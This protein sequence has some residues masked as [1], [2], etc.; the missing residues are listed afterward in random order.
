MVL[1][2][3]ALKTINKNPI[4]LNCFSRGGS[5]ILWN[6][7]ISHPSVCHPLQ[8]TLE[9]FG[10]NLRS[11]KYEA[12]KICTLE[13]YNVFNQWKLYKR[14]PFSKRTKTYIDEVFFNKKLGCFYDNVMKFKSENVIYTKEE[15][16]KSRLIIKNNNGISFFTENFFELY[17]DATFIG[18]IRNPI[19]LYESH[20]RRKTP[21]SKSVDTFTHFYHKMVKKMLRDQSEIP[22]FHIIKF[23]DLISDPV[24]SIQK[25]YGW[26]GLDFSDIKKV[27]LKAKP[28]TMEN[29]IIGN[30]HTFGNHYWFSFKELKTFLDPNVNENQIDKISLNDK[31][32]I[33]TDLS[34]IIQNLDY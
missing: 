8:E 6:F 33:L 20:K 21:V 13:K 17:P 15:V 5:N 22:N 24:K 23:E 26:A 3:Q 30:S 28:F 14:K 9:I 10:I 1:S 32:K 4:I 27:R 31:S 11:F 34:E 25:L 18:L 16:L 12:F 29:G 7:F 19:A 2:T